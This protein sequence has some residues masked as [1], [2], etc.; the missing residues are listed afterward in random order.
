MGLQLVSELKFDRVIIQSD[1][2]VVVDCVIS[3]SSIAVLD[4]IMMDCNVLISNLSDCVVMFIRR[5]LNFDAHHMV[6]VGR[7]YGSKTW[8]DSPKHEPCIPVYC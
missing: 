2:Q 6:G 8:L 3:I 4:P 7:N 1:A 5:A